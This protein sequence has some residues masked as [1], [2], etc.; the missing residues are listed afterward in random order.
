MSEEKQQEIQQVRPISPNVITFCNLIARIVMR[1]L[2]E[3]DP[4]VMKVLFPHW[5]IDEQ[6][7]GEKHDAAA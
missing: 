4:E 7:T 1:C 2:R 3:R 5:Q 6:E